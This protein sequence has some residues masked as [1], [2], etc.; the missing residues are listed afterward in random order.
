VSVYKFTR[1]ITTKWLLKGMGTTKHNYF[2]I[3]KLM[4][5]TFALCKYGRCSVMKQVLY[6]STKFCFLLTNRELPF[7][8]ESSTKYQR[9]P[10]L[11]NFKGA[12]ERPFAVQPN[13]IMGN[14][15]EMG[16]P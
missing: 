7:V 9:I 8:D 11:F 15:Y 4:T 14:K 5:I 10:P 12:G 16:C 13:S 1:N 2:Q 3:T 6:F